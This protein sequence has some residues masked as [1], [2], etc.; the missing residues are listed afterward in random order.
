MQRKLKIPVVW[1]LICLCM[2][3]T[4]PASAAGL[5]TRTVSAAPKT[6]MSF[7]PGVIPIGYDKTKPSP[8]TE[9]KLIWD[10]LLDGIGDEIAV[11][12]IIGNIALESYFYANNLQDS[13]NRSTGLSDVEY[14]KLVDSGSYSRYRFIN[15]SHG[16]GFCQWTYYTL[17]EKL[18][19]YCKGRGYSIGNAAAQ[20]EFLLYD[21]KNNNSS[22]LGKLK[23]ASTIYDATVLFLTE[24]ERP[25]D[26]GYSVRKERAAAGQ[27]CYEKFHGQTYS[28]GQTGWQRINGIWWY[29][30]ADGS[31]PVSAWKE[32]GG[33]WYYFDENGFMQTG[34]RKIGNAWY[35]FNT[36]GAMLSGW[37]KISSKWYYFSASGAMQTD[38]RTISNKTYYFK[39]NGAMAAGEWCKGWWLNKDGTWT[40]KYKATWRKNTK[41]W[42]YGDESGWYAKSCTIKIDGKNYTFDANGYMK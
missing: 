33:K 10:M 40:Y 39:D 9:E 13:S 22:L 27:E 14:T 41:G 2:L 8:D 24:Y 38:W 15:D 25:A 17:K 16:Y 12:G 30:N 26:Q 1:I 35:Y 21:L 36:S 23:K 4:S 42:W 19:D 7:S 6:S 32:I 11:A 20:I 31:Y 34:W 3:P 37:Q 18:Y 28:A 29:R 5:G